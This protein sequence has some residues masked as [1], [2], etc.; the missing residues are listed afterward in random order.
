MIQSR[1]SIT[2]LFLLISL[3]T[4]L[5]AIHLLSLRPDSWGSWLGLSIGGIVGVV[6]C[7]PIEKAIKKK[8][9]SDS[10]NSKRDQNSNISASVSRLMIPS[11]IGG[12]LLAKLVSSIFSFEI[13][14][15]INN[16]IFAWI[17]IV[18]SYGATLA[19]RFVPD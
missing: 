19:W 2:I 5:F 8:S 17:V 1:K 14:N 16:F 10:L 11:V 9:L 7:L 12:M 6:S 15:L 4:G 18:F 13:Q 3:V